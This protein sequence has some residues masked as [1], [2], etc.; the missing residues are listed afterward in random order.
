MLGVGDM[1]TEQTGLKGPCSPLR[2][3][4][5][6]LQA[7]PALLFYENFH[8]P[9]DSTANLQFHGWGHVVLVTSFRSGGTSCYEM[10][11]L[12][13][14]MQCEDCD[15]EDPA[16]PRGWCWPQTEGRKGNLL[17]TRG[18]QAAPLR[19]TVSL[20]SHSVMSDSLRPNRLPHT[21]LPCPSPTPQAYSNSCPLSG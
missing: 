14:M 5:G 9:W 12:L 6:A 13:G 19:R 15:D 8:L 10:S 7:A 18:Q 16:S 17:S 4:S 21:R 2:R 11:W 20:F 3:V 1:Q